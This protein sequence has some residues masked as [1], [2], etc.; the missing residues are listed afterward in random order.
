MILSTTNNSRKKNTII[1]LRNT[2]L[3]AMHFGL[4]KGLILRLEKS[5]FPDTKNRPQRPNHP[6]PSKKRDASQLLLKLLR[7]PRA[8][9]LRGQYLFCTVESPAHTDS[10]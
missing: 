10:G 4:L 9:M 6:L 5:R 7:L 8:G 3:L 2:P 1:T